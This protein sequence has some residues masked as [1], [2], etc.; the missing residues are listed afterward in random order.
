MSPGEGSLFYHIGCYDMNGV[1]RYC[2]KEGEAEL[3]RRMDLNRLPGADGIMRGGEDLL[4]HLIDNGNYHYLSCL[5]AQRIGT[6]FALV[7]IDHHA[8]MRPSAFGEDDDKGLLSC[9]G[10]VRTLA[11]RNRH[12][13]QVVMI[14]VEE[15]LFAEE[16]ALL[17][18]GCL[19]G[20]DEPGMSK[21]AEKGAGVSVVRI[22]GDGESPQHILTALGETLSETLPVVLSVDKDVLSA[23]EVETNWDQG[24][25][26]LDA[27]CE[28]ITGICRSYRVPVFDLCGAPDARTA[29][30]DALLQNSAADR[31]LLAAAGVVI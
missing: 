7:L 16:Y 18:E 14:G 29:H 23:E 10:W 3:L 25:M 30:A 24:R 15:T 20:P 5:L 11:A 22:A 28:V 27:L 17:A 2:T 9:G 1:S 19:P 8:D 13:R 4:V 31:A 21:E 6:P 12:L 26:R